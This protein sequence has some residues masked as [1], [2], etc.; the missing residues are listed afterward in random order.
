[1]LH[2]GGRIVSK[3]SRHVKEHYVYHSL[4][5]FSGTAS[6]QVTTKDVDR[7]H[8]MELLFGVATHALCPRVAVYVLL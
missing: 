7:T 5:T 8:D 1:M 3:R 6:T 4:Q 2:G